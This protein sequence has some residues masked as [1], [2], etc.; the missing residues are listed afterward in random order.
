MLRNLT[1]LIGLL[2][3][4]LLLFGAYVTARGLDPAVRSD[5]LAHYHQAEALIAG[6]LLIVLLGA[7]GQSNARRRLAAPL[8]LALLVAGAQIA[9]PW[10][11]TLQLS[12]ASSFQYLFHQVCAF[13]VL[14]LLYRA[15]LNS[16]EGADA[17]NPAGRAVRWSVAATR[18]VWVLAVLDGFWVV[19]SG[20]GPA[21]PDIPTCWGHAWPEV[22]YLSAHAFWQFDFQHMLPMDLPQRIGVHWLHRIAGL[23][24]VVWLTGLGWWLTAARYGAQVNRSGLLINGLI[25]L[26]LASGW[27]AVHWKLPWFA[28][29]LHSLTAAGLWLSLL[30]AQYFLA[31][32]PVPSAL[33]DHD[34]A[35][36]ITAADAAIAVAPP[37]APTPEPVADS[38]SLFQR[39][40]GGLRK[41]RGGFANL[42]A[43]LPLGRQKL[44]DALLEDIETTL[45]M[46]D[47]GVEA[48]QSLVKALVDASRDEAEA[49]SAERLRHTLKTHML[50]LLTPCES[51][52]QVDSSK[53]PFVILVVGVNGVG[54]TT[55]IGK[56]ARRLQSEG[57]SVMLAAGDTFRAAAVEQLQVWGERNGIPVVAQSTGADSA[58]VL[59]DALQSAQ[60]K[61]MDV[62]IADT[63]GRLHTK[64]NL[65][66]ELKKI[67]RILGKLDDSAPHEV[68]LVLDAGTGQNAI[69]QAKQF[70]AAVELTGIVLTKL[71]GTAKGG[72]IFALARQLGVPIRYIGVG[73]T[74]EDLQTFQAEAFIDALLEQDTA[75]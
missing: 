72:V 5:W 74:I 63:A 36:I 16:S 45:L 14:A 26:Q 73:E 65:M 66:D 35:A 56:L 10:L 49:M 37:A 71:D 6:L 51:P 34:T 11:Q 33:A 21:C 69:V 62:L 41:T 28:T 59:Y 57:K 67:K 48:S 9:L 39:L 54:K 8:G 29:A 52:L 27:A 22:D 64:S 42:L 55:T 40:R 38:A 68:L 19:A 31:R 32:L 50:D 47:V 4:A 23:A 1:L 46:A 13:V 20:S 25:L 3:G 17:L 61:N 53:R 12:L 58:S 44:D 24:L 18:A 30:R 15:W 2:Q 75:N 43:A 70:H 60:A 7:L